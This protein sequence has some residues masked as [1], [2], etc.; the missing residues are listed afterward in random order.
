ML[1]NHTRI[2]FD[3]AQREEA[4]EFVSTLVEYSK[5]EDGTVRYH[6]MIDIDAPDVVR[7]FELYEDVAAAETHTESVQYR[8]FVESLTDLVDG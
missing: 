8:R 5:T 3:S 7:F 1:A 4:M 2:P 6:A